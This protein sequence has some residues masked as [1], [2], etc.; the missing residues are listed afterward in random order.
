MLSNNKI[1]LGTAKLGMPE[2]GFSDGR[3]LKD[4]I[5]FLLKSLDLGIKSFDTSSRYGNSEE[6]IGKALKNSQKTACVNTKVDHLEP[7][8]SNT[9]NLMLNLI[10]DS[11][12]KLTTDID[13]CYLH[14][15]DIKIISDKYVHQGIKLLKKNNLVKEIG[16]SIYSKEELIYTLEC[17]IF[18][19][20][21]IPVNILDTSFYHIISNHN[22]QIKIA[23][24]SVFLQGILINDQ[25][26][27]TCIKRNNQLLNTLNKIN[28]LCSSSGITIQQ[29]SIAYLMHLDRINQVII[30][31]VSK[32]KLKDNICSTKI[33]LQKTLISS[34]HDI[35][36][37]PKSWTNPRNWLS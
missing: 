16:T 24:R 36:Y 3:V 11:I 37:L 25:W 35:S 14:Q 34:I 13:V 20:V 33:K 23:A 6:L 8:N 27:R 5:D 30:G 10:N 2:Y 21:Q 9:P 28:E 18:D 17:G 7:K 19:W 15:N 22:S 32:N 1:S 31:T 29:L 12:S 4:P 26:A